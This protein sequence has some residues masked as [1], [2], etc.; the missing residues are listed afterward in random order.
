[1]WYQQAFGETGAVHWSRPYID[2]ATGEYVITASKAVVTGNSVIGVVGVDINLATLTEE[3][4]ESQ[5]GFQGYAV[6]LDEEGTAIVHPTERDNNLAEESY[7]AEMYEE[8]KESGVIRYTLDGEDKILIYKTLPD[9]GWK[10]GASY[11]QKEI[12]KTASES[13]KSLVLIALI[14]EII[15]FIILI[16]MT[17]RIIRPLDRLKKAMEKVSEGDLT[18]R[19]DIKSKDEIGQLARDF[20]IMIDSMN[21]VI[22]VVNNSVDNVRKSAESLSAASEETNASSEEM[23]VAVNEIAMGAA[24][25]AEDSEEVN[26]RSNML[27]DQISEISEKAGSM[28]EIAGRANIINQDG[29]KQMKHL[30][31]SYQDWKDHLQSMADVIGQLD[32]KVKAIGIVME[33]ITQISSQTNLLALN[34]SIEAARAGEHGR[35]F[36]VVAEEVRKLAEQSSQST[37]EVKI[38]V[39]ELLSGAQQVT[40]QML[41]TRGSFV[42]QETVVQDTEASF[43]EIS[44]L[45][46]DM[47]TSI[48]S[49]YI[50]VQKVEEHKEE[51]ASTIQTMAATSEE[52][53]A[54]CEEVSASTDEQL[55]AIQ[56]V[57]ESAEQLTELSQNLQNAVSRFKI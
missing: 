33:T 56:S 52:T 18:V 47:Q 53:A 48:D 41:E 43:A 50:E 3:I 25:S 28:N 8:N 26:E 49:V 38:T 17:N 45:M 34:A 37:E 7:V 13:N 54:A 6:I 9:V 4:S 30:K 29:Q 19:S 57:A 55:R 32:H 23:A 46:T 42:Q 27:S 11:F 15:T 22:T 2:A 12:G 16:V 21:S 40:K 51:V 36:A 5:L 1:M 44:L 35:G 10:V 31:D 14:T 20:N 24:R 39:Q